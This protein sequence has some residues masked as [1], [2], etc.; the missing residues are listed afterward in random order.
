MPRALANTSRRTPRAGG[1]R[2]VARALAILRAFEGGGS[3]SLGEIASVAALD[4][5]TTRRLLLTLIEARFVA[6][7]ANTQHYALGGA[8]RSLAAVA[9]ESVDLRSM[10][11][12]V[13]IALAAEMHM[14]VFLSIYRDSQAICLDRFH[15]LQG[16][17]VRWW[18]VGGT[19]PLNCGGA[20]KLLLA[21]QSSDEIDRVLAQP[22]TALTPKSIV[23]PTLLRERLKRI[24]KQGYCFAID[25]VALGLS[26]L[27]MPIFD[28]DG[29]LLCSIS[30]SGLTPQMSDRGR[31]IQ[32]DRL[33]V[34][35]EM[36]KACL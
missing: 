27:A 33:R 20:P 4:K 22:L 12:P 8:I 28:R 19:L 2:A 10:T 29:G 24:R 34:S 32:L 16:M 7:D 26:A 30:M 9:P 18:S 13:L 31:P 15:D 14:T 5:G 17:E 36:I 11:K 23:D 21:H 25:D 1:V 6:Q 3:L 35:A